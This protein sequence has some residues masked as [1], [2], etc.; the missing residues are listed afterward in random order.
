MYS[1][2]RRKKV[3][4]GCRHLSEHRPLSEMKSGIA[5][6]HKKVSR[7]DWKAGS[8]SRDTEYISREH[9]FSCG[10]I[11]VCI[12]QYPGGA[13]LTAEGCASPP[14][15]KSPAAITTGHKSFPVSGPQTG[16]LSSS[17]QGTEGIPL[18]TLLFSFNVLVMEWA[19][20]GVRW[21]CPPDGVS[22]LS[23]CV[24]WPAI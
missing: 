2:L 7:E 11:V 18:A 10:G 16:S 8:I 17:T 5:Y 20:G 19:W 21:P 13:P 22:H 9:C 12:L 6:W 3:K 14:P 4:K 15:A 24:A 23:P 1:S